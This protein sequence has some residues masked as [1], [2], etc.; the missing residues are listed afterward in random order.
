MLRFTIII[1][2]LLTLVTAAC[3]DVP[4]YKPNPYGTKPG[5]ASGNRLQGSDRFNNLNLGSIPTPAQRQTQ[6]TG[7]ECTKKDLGFQV[8]FAREQNGRHTIPYEFKRTCTNIESVDIS[9]E[10]A[11]EAY[12]RSPRPNEKGYLPYKARTDMNSDYSCEVTNTTTSNSYW[13]IKG[14]VCL[15]DKTTTTT[16]T[17]TETGV[18]DPSTTQQDNGGEAEVVEVATANTGTTGTCKT[19]IKDDIL[20]FN[21]T[22]LKRECQKACLELTTSIEEKAAKTESLA[23]IATTAGHLITEISNIIYNSDKCIASRRKPSNQENGTKPGT[24]QGRQTARL[25]NLDGDSESDDPC[26]GAKMADFIGTAV[27]AAG[28]VMQT[29]FCSKASRWHH[30]SADYGCYEPGV[31]VKCG[32]ANDAKNQFC[33]NTIS[34]PFGNNAPSRTFKR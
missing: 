19:F 26:S 9:I 34:S 13:M 24:N 11:G 28:Q 18:T 6:E 21:T 30:Q 12:C 8:V 29:L 10:G 14:K 5:N 1:S 31:D 25:V 7:I 32:E 20:I 27:I 4:P 33:G 23:R 22:Q 3:D 16:T 15:K 17:T 2:I